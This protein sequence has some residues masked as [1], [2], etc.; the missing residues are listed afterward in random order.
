MIPV[1]AVVFPKDISFGSS[2]GPEF[3]TDIV[4]LGDDRE[5]RNQAWE[6]PRERWNVAYGVRTNTQ[7]DVLRA[8]FHARIGMAR[9]FLFENPRD[10]MFYECVIGVGDGAKKVFQLSKDYADTTGSIV[11]RRKVSRPKSGALRISLDGTPQ[12]GGWTC[13]YTTGVVTFAPGA[14]GNG[15]VLT[16]DCDCFYFPMRFDTDYLSSTLE[17]YMA[18]STEVPL[19][20]VRP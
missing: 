12:I 8:F 1:D 6:F 2:G 11:Y 7:L 5:Q 20:E 17:D 10:F 3:K 13:D 9:G 4:I 14:P 19:I 15:A 18:E 16:A